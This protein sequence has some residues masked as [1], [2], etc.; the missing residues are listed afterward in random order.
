MARDTQPNVYANFDE[1][2]RRGAAIRARHRVRHT[3]G[4]LGHR[5][6]KVERRKVDAARRNLCLPVERDADMWREVLET[7]DGG[8][9]HTQ[10]TGG[11]CCK[12]R[13]PAQAYKMSS[14]LVAVAVMTTAAIVDIQRIECE[15]ADKTLSVFGS[16]RFIT[17]QVTIVTADVNRR[18]TQDYCIV[19]YA[20]L[21]QRWVPCFPCVPADVE[22]ARHADNDL[23]FFSVL[24]LIGVLAGLFAIWTR[25][26]LWPLIGGCD[27]CYQL[28]SHGDDRD[29]SLQ[30]IV[31]PH[32]QTM[33][34][35]TWPTV[36]DV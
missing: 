35:T 27:N 19:S 15:I 10:F 4:P 12:R 14:L 32:A 29:R 16:V 21:D 31:A 33:T 22:L 6:A 24:I 30:R 23:L 18:E 26:T 13:R 17:E 36:T 8:R 7:V 28:A 3:A 34:P 2:E 9:R 5:G 20:D 1:L 11:V 25:P